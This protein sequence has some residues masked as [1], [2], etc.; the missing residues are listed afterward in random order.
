MHSEWTPNAGVATA[1]DGNGRVDDFAEKSSTFDLTRNAIRSNPHK[2]P[3]AIHP[4]Q[5]QEQ[6]RQHRQAEEKP[7]PFERL[8]VEVTKRLGAQVRSPVVDQKAPE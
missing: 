6:C 4:Q 1:V 2:N 7:F 3:V 8:G 5:H